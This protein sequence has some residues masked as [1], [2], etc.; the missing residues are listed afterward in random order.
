MV[1]VDIDAAKRADARQASLVAELQHRLRNVLAV[2]RS[3][4]RR[5]AEAGDD[6]EDFAGHLEGR[7]AALARTQ[8]LL[9]RGAD[10]GVDLEMLIREELLSQA[11]EES[12]LKIVGPSILLS[13]KAAE[14][15]T[16]AVHELATNA[17]KYGALAQGGSISVAWAVESRGESADWL[18]L[19]WVER[20]VRVVAAGPRR[21]GVGAALI[22]GRIPHDRAGAGRLNFRPGGLE[23]EICIPLIAGASVLRPAQG[24]DE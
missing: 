1:V 12:R 5:T 20:G 23:A 22:E 16:L 19:H 8:S 17:V 7:I 21:R 13:Y 3:V 2:V 11:A 14:A 9:A 15:L 4:V 24:P 6:L 10:A 18:R